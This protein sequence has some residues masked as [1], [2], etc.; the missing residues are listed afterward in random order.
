MLEAPGRP[1][2]IG[3]NYISGLRTDDPANCVLLY[4]PEGLHAYGGWALFVDGR[5]E[6]VQ[7]R[8]LR[9]KVRSTTTAFEGKLGR[10][11]KIAPAETAM[12]DLSASAQAGGG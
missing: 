8:T 6:W 11:V 5:L 12:P 4:T 2:G 7:D 9:A 1:G 10:D 3:F